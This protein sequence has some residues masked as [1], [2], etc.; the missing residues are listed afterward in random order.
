MSSNDYNPTPHVIP[1]G[2]NA[3]PLGVV[4]GECT[5]SEKLIIVMC[6]LPATG[7]THI[8]NRIVRYLSFFLDIPTKI[9]NVGDYRRKLYG[10][11]LPAAFF[12][13]SNE[14]FMSKRLEACDGALEDLIS[15]MKEDGVRV[16]VLDSTN[17]NRG[18]RDHIR[19]ALN[20]LECKVVFLECI[21]NDDYVLESNIRNIHLNTPDY[22]GMD[23][24]AAFEDFKKR[25][26]NYFDVYEHVDNKDG[27]HIKI[28][29]NETFVVYNVRGYLPQKVVH[30]VMNLHLLPREFYL[31]RHGQSMYNLE[32]KIGGDSGLSEAG[33]EYARRLADFAKDVVATEVKV[34]EETGE[35]KRVARPARLWTSTLRRTKETAQFIKKEKMTFKWDNHDEVTWIQFKGRARRNLDELYAGV[36]DGLTYQE[37]KERFPEEFARRQENKLTYRY[38]RAHQGIHRLLY[39]YFM[40]LSREEAPFVSIPLNTIIEIRPHAYGCTEKRYVLL[41]KEEMLKDGQ[42]EPI[43]SMPMQELS[44]R[45]NSH[46]PRSEST[47]IDPMNPPSF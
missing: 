23:A 1:E 7:K 20:T 41:S 47:S 22:K 4:G 2:E 40:G 15:F 33:L 10:A 31:S 16:G 18:R 45:A 42:D 3:T 11:Q 8:A 24:V 32:G 5:D 25:R 34:D 37:I 46:H 14:A 30:F 6:G 28:I 21:V 12:D 44:D 29:N 38:P 17:A 9:F 19:N 36:C 43:T 26:E 13:H 35:E 27:A 39:A